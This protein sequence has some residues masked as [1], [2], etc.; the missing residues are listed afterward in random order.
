MRHL[1]KQLECLETGYLKHHQFLTGDRLT[2]A[3]SFV[4]T[5]ILQAQWNGFRFQM[6][7]KVERWLRLVR[8]QEF[9]SQVHRVH[10]E[11]VR[12]LEEQPF[13]FD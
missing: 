11:L 1:A 10:N 13:E 8:A 7:P 2:V 3:D 12:E 4:A 5:V 9:W 6:W